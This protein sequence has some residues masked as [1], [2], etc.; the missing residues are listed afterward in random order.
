VLGSRDYYIEAL[1]AFQAQFLP[2]SHTYGGKYLCHK[3][4]VAA[5]GRLE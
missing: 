4:G 1:A 5:N 2:F 3:K